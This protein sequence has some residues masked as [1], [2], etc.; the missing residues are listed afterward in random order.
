MGGLFVAAL[1]FLLG[2]V[3]LHRATWV[4]NETVL[5]ARA[6]ELP[7]IP[8]GRVR[9]GTIVRIEGS[10]VGPAVGAWLEAPVGRAECVAYSLE[11]W[12]L[13]TVTRGVNFILESDGAR[14]RVVATRL[15]LA[16]AGQL[17]HR[18]RTSGR[19]D[20]ILREGEVGPGVKTAVERTLTAGRRVVVIGQASEHEPD[21]DG[22]PVARGEGYRDL[23][24]PT[25]VVIAPR[26]MSV[27]VIDPPSERAAGVSRGG[28]VPG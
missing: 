7:S 14:A 16:T 9:V 18:S 19:L 24:R 22:T 3:A 25:R 13:A 6:L 1:A 2:G 12:G 20:A 23:V 8:I 27:L 28:G 10:I 26:A 21:P 5:R 17:H 11:A 15:E 4:P